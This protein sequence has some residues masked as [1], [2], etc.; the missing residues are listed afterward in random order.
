MKKYILRFALYFLFLQMF[1]TTYLFSQNTIQSNELYKGSIYLKDGTRIKSDRILYSN[2]ILQYK[3]ISTNSV[4]SLQINSIDYLRLEN[5]TYAAEGLGIG[6][7]SGILADLRVALNDNYHRISPA[8]YPVCIAV[9]A[10]VGFLI[11]VVT[12]N[13][14]TFYPPN[15]TANLNYDTKSDLYVSTGQANLKFNLTI[16]Y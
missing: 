1:T 5:G 7:L 13:T 3:N 2:K 14:S 10:G 12:K 11:G 8:F 4:D 6:L 16:N 9:T 15:V